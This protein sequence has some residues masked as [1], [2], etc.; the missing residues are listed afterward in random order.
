GSAV[1]WTHVIDETAK[2]D[3]D[4]I[5]PGHGPLS[6]RAG[7]MQWRAAF[8]SMRDHIGGMVKSGASKEHVSKV[9]LDEFKWPNGGLAIGQ[10]DAFIAEMKT[11]ST[12]A[13]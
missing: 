1:E 6:D 3:F 11:A 12:P 4:T 10:V 7:L 13:R 5:I 8:V 9:L 2:L